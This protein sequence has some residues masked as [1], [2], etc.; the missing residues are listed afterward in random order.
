MDIELSLT[1][2]LLC[3]IVSAGRWKS[4]QKKSLSRKENTMEHKLCNICFALTMPKREGDGLR[5]SVLS[6]ESLRSSSSSSA[7]ELRF[8]AGA[9]AVLPHHIPLGAHM[10]IL[11][12][13]EPC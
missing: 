6:S 10:W 7:M 9:T 2:N 8:G 4:D 3:W 1:E 11:S 13:E 5:G 12:T